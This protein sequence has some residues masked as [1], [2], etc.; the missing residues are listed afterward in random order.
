MFQTIIIRSFACHSIAK[1]CFT[2]TTDWQ[3]SRRT[4]LNLSLLI[5]ITFWS[6]KVPF[7][8]CTFS[9]TILTTT[10]F[11]LFILKLFIHLCFIQLIMKSMNEGGIVTVDHL[12]KKS[13]DEL[14]IIFLTAAVKVHRLQ[15]SSVKVSIFPARCVDFFSFPLN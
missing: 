10:L 11:W 4:I 14:K 8:C 2:W 1:I 3:W 12:Q 13:V 5:N 15:L 7:F 9:P 6:S